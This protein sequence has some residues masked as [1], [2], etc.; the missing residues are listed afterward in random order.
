MEYGRQRV[1]LLAHP[2]EMKV[3][4]VTIKQC[5]S[6]PVGDFLW[7]LVDGSVERLS[8][9]IAERKTVKD[10]VLSIFDGRYRDKKLTSR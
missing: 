3:P 1:L 5:R 8:G 4:T 2:Q 9:V 6:L 10:L 7:L